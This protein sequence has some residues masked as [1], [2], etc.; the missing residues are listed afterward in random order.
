MT[1]LL[2]PKCL[3]VIP[4]LGNNHG[5]LTPHY[6][7]LAKEFSP[8]HTV[9]L[10]YIDDPSL[11]L[12]LLEIGRDPYNIVIY[13]W[14]GYDMYHHCQNVDG[15][16]KI[17]SLLKA[18]Q[19]A[20]VD[21]HAFADFMVPRLEGGSDKV[22]Y[23]C[24]DSCFNQELEEIYAIAPENIFNCTLP[25]R[26]DS[27]DL[28]DLTTVDRKIDVLIPLSPINFVNYEHFKNKYLDEGPIKKVYDS[29]NY[30]LSKSYGK[31]D[32][33]KTFSNAVQLIFDSS[34]SQLP[35]SQRRNLLNFLHE[36]D[37]LVRA[38]ERSRVIQKVLAIP[39]IGVEIAQIPTSI[40]RESILAEVTEFGF[41]PF[42][43]IGQ[44]LKN[45]KYILNVCPTSPN[46]IHERVL[47]GMNL[48]CGVISNLNIRL[49]SV[50]DIIYDVDG[51]KPLEEMIKDPLLL[52]EKVKKGC[53]FSSQFSY[54]NFKSFIEKI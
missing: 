39:G 31:F 49:S 18:K 52:E 21:D 37:Y 11:L 10:R 43:E 40:S 32:I 15:I 12:D 29:L 44:K 28:I 24:S 48:G 23:I 7:S 16:T 19:I 20:Y 54:Q 27:K 2:K 50:E 17:A 1:N 34:F 45:S 47:Y 36:Y 41:V 25:A 38:N 35:L 6:F 14:F 51:V 13:G 53:D 46:S 4:K 5:V 3:L 30:E 42:D 9:S 26:I 8:T 22:K 33:F